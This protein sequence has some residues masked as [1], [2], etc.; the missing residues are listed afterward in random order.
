[1]YGCNINRFKQ[2]LFLETYIFSLNLVLLH[3][4]YVLHVDKNT[5]TY[6]VLT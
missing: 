2:I 6:D 3:R 1:M 5:F 4:M